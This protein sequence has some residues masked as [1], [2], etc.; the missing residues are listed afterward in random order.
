MQF[1]SFS[2]DS[3]PESVSCGRFVAP[4]GWKHSSRLIDS[5]VLLLGVQGSIF[6]SQD[7]INYELVPG[8]VLLLLPGRQHR[9]FQPSQR[10]ASYYWCHFY[11]DKNSKWL[12]LADLFAVLHRYRSDRHNSSI[13]LPVF[14][15][16]SAPERIAI[17]FRQLI[18]AH[19]HNQHTPFQC[20]L[21]LAS[22]GAEITEQV[23]LH[24]SQTEDDPLSNKFNEALEWI[25][26]NYNKQILVNDIAW[27]FN[28]NANYFSRLFKSK[29]GISLI[30]YVNQLK[31]ER[32][33]YLLVNSDLSVK[34]ISYQIGIS[35]EKYFMKLFRSSESLTPTQY[36]NAFSYTHLND[37]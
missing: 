36:R 18:H 8:Q 33:R 12:D 11:I 5:Y 27:R 10:G 3:L 28:Y 35:D 13:Y 30:R 20:N 29:M 23:F 22:I 32:S 16:L 25:R 26:I 4:A 15:S 7:D 31:I 37:H 24:F 19:M 2:H 21:C 17:I 14:F 1:L 6:I 9:G 34:E